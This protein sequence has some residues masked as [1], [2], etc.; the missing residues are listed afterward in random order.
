MS[1]ALA[2]STPEQA[3]TL[4]AAVAAMSLRR[5]LALLL[6]ALA[7][8]LAL[9]P[10]PGF[11]TNEGAPSVA[12]VTVSS[13]PGG[14]G[15]YGLGETIRVTLSFSEAVAV[16][17]T[18]RLAIDMDPADWGRKWASY[19]SGSG[20]SGLTFAYTVVEP[21]YSSQGIAVLANT[22]ELNGGSITSTASQAAADLSHV[23]KGHD[24]AHKVDWQL[25]PPAPNQAPLVN[26]G[27]QNHQ[28]FVAEHNAPR[29]VLVSKIFAGLFSDPDGDQLT[30]TVSI[31]G[32]RAELVDDLVIGS[33]GRSDLLA[34]QSPGPR[35]ASQRVF[36][37]VDDEDDWDA[38]E[39]ALQANPVITVTLTA[40]DPSGLSA[41]VQG[42][43][44]I[45]WEP[46]EEPGAA[47]TQLNLDDDPAN[48]I[49]PQN[50]G[51]DQATGPAVTDV[52]V[53]SDAGSDDFYELGE[54]VHVSLTFSETVDVTGSPY[55]NIDM[56]PAYWG[57]KVVPYVSGSGTDTLTF[58]HTVIE[59]NYSMQGIAVLANSLR[60]NGGTI[61][62]TSTQANA[63]LAH[64]G[65]DHQS[66]HRVNWLYPAQRPAAPAVTYIAISSD[67][68]DDRSYAKGEVIR[69]TLR[70]SE[71]VTVTGAPRL[72]L[73]LQEGD[74][75]ERWASYESGSGST[76]LVFAYTVA[77]GD[78][79]QEG[80]AV[81]ANSLALNGGAIVSASDGDNALLAHT[82][83]RRNANHRLDCTPPTLLTAVADGTTLTLTF[84]E[85][86]GAAASLSNDQ[87][88]VVRTPEGGT[89]ESIGLTGAPVISSVTVT[90][91]LASAV[92]ESDTDVKVSYE[93]PTT[94]QSN[95][96]ID[97][98][99][100]EVDSF[101]D[102][103][104][105]EDTTP[106]R[107]VRG[108]VDGDTLYVY[109]SEAMDP[110]SFGGWFR[111]TLTLR[112]GHKHSFSANGGVEIEGNKVIVRMGQS[113]NGIPY[114]AKPGVQHNHAFYLWEDRPGAPVLRDLAGN[115]V[116]AHSLW[117]GYY[118]TR[119]ILLENIT[120]E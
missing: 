90:L 118:D 77:E 99:G 94:G 92:L 2:R 86:L 88:A 22:L 4:A 80:V 33:W 15:G 109:F 120:P 25:S 24:P 1:L 96:L 85:E 29:G 11:A 19:E 93:K 46:K 10:A 110:T 30:Y 23:G 38:L 49:A 52:E 72:K 91:S 119:S 108:Q 54:T 3:A 112:N 47:L 63:A 34:A 84:D 32:G 40:T 68:G 36:I 5:R 114:I 50:S 102:V 51:S 59:P 111:V 37:E 60:L 9:T 55:L 13:V 117:G 113:W 67:A 14:D 53:T 42:D 8:L 58:V 101:S 70:L 17:G 18:P 62:S 16:T 64:D 83:L 78:D 65:L 107:L 26:T 87:F 56:D 43:F 21:N 41:S 71:A 106:P 95:K 103:S 73:D 115:P 7:A 74:G 20:T 44:V 39:P 116:E 66:A 100:N 27:T 57:T 69:V 45:A 79:S 89:E 105:M 61:R 104:V 35:E 76:T 28:R 82:G 75:D 12:L 48:S 97:V 81:P 31:T 98:V 6:V